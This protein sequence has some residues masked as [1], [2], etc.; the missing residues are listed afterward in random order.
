MIHC[1]GLHVVIQFYWSA[2]LKL[3]QIAFPSIECLWWVCD[4]LHSFGMR[5]RLSEK[6]H[7]MSVISSCF[8]L[9]SLPA[10]GSFDS[11]FLERLDGCQCRVGCLDGQQRIHLQ[12]QPLRVSSAEVRRS[13]VLKHVALL[14][15]TDLSRDPLK[16]F[17]KSFICSCKD[18]SRTEGPI[19]VLGRVSCVPGQCL[20]GTTLRH[21]L[22]GSSTKLW[23]RI[24]RGPRC[25]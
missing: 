3:F 11:S 1:V 15:F 23:R 2:T 6:R 25:Q 4:L 17:T 16:K 7:S 20:E 21:L 22:L 10:D 12:I 19:V 8:T 18:S 24:R 13:P 5:H 9:Q 14:D